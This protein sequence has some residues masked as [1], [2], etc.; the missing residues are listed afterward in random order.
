MGIP[1]TD[2][3]RTFAGHLGP[4]SISGAVLSATART[5]NVDKGLAT[6]PTA[7]GAN[8]MLA[9]MPFAGTFAGARLTFID[10]LAASDS[11]YITVE[12]KNRGQAGAGTTD[13]LAA[14][15]GNTTKVT[16]GAALVAKGKRAL[17]THGTAANLAIAAGDVVS[18]LVTVTGT[19]ANT[20]TG[21]LCELLLDC[22][23]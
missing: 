20:L 8:E 6:I 21:G 12:L 17:I 16:G 1:I 9:L 3:P 2:N 15:A 14:V 5:K 19:L 4:G 23:G 10:A 18:I 11:N 7:A 22:P 13:L